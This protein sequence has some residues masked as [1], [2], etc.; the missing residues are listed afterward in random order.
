MGHYRSLASWRYR[1]SWDSG[2]RPLVGRSISRESRAARCRALRSGA[3]VIRVTTWHELSRGEYD[4]RAPVCC[5]LT[6]LPWRSLGISLTVRQERCRDRG[7][8]EA[9]AARTRTVAAQVSRA[10]R[11]RPGGNRSQIAWRRYDYEVTSCWNSRNSMARMPT[12]ISPVSV[13]KSRLTLRECEI[14]SFAAG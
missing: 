2:D 1:P 5:R 11:S 12:V 10:L 4:T 14:P 13:R 9:D 7:G 8:R 3:R 6:A